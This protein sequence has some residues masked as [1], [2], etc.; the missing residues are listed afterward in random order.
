LADKKEYRIEEEKDVVVVPEKI[1]SKKIDSDALSVAIRLLQKKWLVI[2][3]PV[4]AIVIALI[5][6][7]M[8]LSAEKHLISA[9]SEFAKCRSSEEFL[10]V[11]QKYAKTEYGAFALE[12]AAK[13][14]LESGNQAKAREL[15]EKFIKEYPKNS[16]VTF[17]KTY[18]PISLENEGKY[19]EAIAEYQKVLENDPQQDIISD[20]LNMRI[21]RCYELKGDLANAKSYYNKV[22]ARAG[23]TAP[24]EGAPSV[25][26]AEAAERLTKIEKKE[27]LLKSELKLEEPKGK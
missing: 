22:V 17:V 6:I 8:R 21:G 24:V 7:L 27:Q 25:W 1:E 16:L 9:A 20:S 5:L 13:I 23:L 14:A 19:S 26:S 11:Y 10:N 12:K 2:G 18:I 15:A 4:A 3:V